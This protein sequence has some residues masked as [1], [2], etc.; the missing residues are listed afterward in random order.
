MTSTEALS[1]GALHCIAMA[2]AVAVASTHTQAHS[3]ALRNSTV[4]RDTQAHISV[5][6][7]P[8]ADVNAFLLFFHH[9]H[10]HCES[11][12]LAVDMS[13]EEVKLLH[14]RS[15]RREEG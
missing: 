4:V 9:H 3:L 13:S 10:H 15:E 8:D 14:T 6:D 12:S 2:A 1:N 5:L 11:E 7:V